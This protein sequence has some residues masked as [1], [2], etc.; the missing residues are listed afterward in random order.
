MW[1]VVIVLLLINL[2]LHFVVVCNTGDIRLVNGNNEME[3]RI[4]V[5]LNNAWG[6]VCDDSWSVEDSNVACG[7]LGFSTSGE[8][9]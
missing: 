9:A 5:C 2:L 3:G 7:Q 6:T 8:Q 1:L 4:E